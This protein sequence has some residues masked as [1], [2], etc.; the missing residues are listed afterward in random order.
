MKRNK[1]TNVKVDEPKKRGK[2][3]YAVKF[4]LSNKGKYSKNSPFYNK[5]K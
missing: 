5:D 1:K 4:A 3:R 2:S